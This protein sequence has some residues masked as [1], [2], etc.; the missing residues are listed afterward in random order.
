MVRC[1]GYSRAA[2]GARCRWRSTRGSRSRAAVAVGSYR[3]T[4][5][6]VL[7]VCIPY[8]YRPS[9]IAPKLASHRTAAPA[10]FALRAQLESEVATL[11]PKV[12]LS[13]A[14]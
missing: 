7:V 12:T 8:A 3:V 5:R 2:A 10:I 13:L 6:Y 11:K 14:V 4:R 9:Y 1:I